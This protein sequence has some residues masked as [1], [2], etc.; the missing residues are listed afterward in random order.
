MHLTPHSCPHEFF[1]VVEAAKDGARADW[2]PDPAHPRVA[3]FDL[4]D[5]LIDLN[6]AWLWT[7]REWRVGR[8]RFGD[9]F[10]SMFV[11]ESP[12]ALLVSDRAHSH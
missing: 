12:S 5:T 11:S 6:S 9:V 7:M 2:R 1:P 10:F 4:D 8:I 3:L